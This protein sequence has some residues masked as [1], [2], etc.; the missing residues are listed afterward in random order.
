M[1]SKDQYIDLLRLKCEEIIS[2]PIKSNNDVAQLEIVL[3]RNISNPISF[4]SLRRFFGLVPQTK[5]IDKTLNKISEGLGYLNFTEFCKST[6]R[7]NSWIY[8]CR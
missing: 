3:N 7:N 8:L 5:P 4:S 6:I 1:K 2:R